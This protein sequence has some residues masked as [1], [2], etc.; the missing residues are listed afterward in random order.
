MFRV[1]GLALGKL[2]GLFWGGW[3]FSH[4]FRVHGFTAV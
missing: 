2:A 1:E 4:E 3:G